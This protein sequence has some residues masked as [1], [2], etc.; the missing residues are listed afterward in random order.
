MPAADAQCPLCQSKDCWTA[1][2]FDRF[3]FLRCG[4]CTLEFCDPLHYN[5]ESY[6]RAYKNENDGFYVPSSAW[7]R[8]ASQGMGE[9]R[10]M[11]FSAQAQ[12]LKWLKSHK[13]NA[14]LLDIGCGPGWFLAR[15]RQLGF[16]VM[17]AEIGSVPVSLLQGRKFK[18]V[19]GSLESI[20]PH[21]N[22]DVVTLFEVLE[23]LPNPAE[24]LSS[25]RSR[26][27]NAIFIF[28]VPSPTRWTKAGNHRDLADYPPN[29]LTRWN[30]QSLQ[31]ALTFAGYSNVE[32]KYSMPS[33]LE[34]ASVSVRGLVKSWSD[35]MPGSLPQAL[36]ASSLR[37]LKREI[38]V[39]KLKCIPGTLLATA[40]RAKGWSGISL[41][42]IARP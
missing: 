41:L 23:H 42:G 25:V 38:A 19:C 13:P 27:R 34:T 33:A 35:R 29:H 1:D 28:S 8:E 15:A 11:L 37:P 22:P 17:G 30:P 2:I 12:A 5:R 40:F 14:S 3:N 20:P 21:W 26:F 31:T 39:R 32:V 4:D 16:K 7:L 9:S 24:F 6:D 10:W 36:A 18:V